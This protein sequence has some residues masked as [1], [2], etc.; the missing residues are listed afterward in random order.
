MGIYDA[1]YQVSHSLC[2]KNVNFDVSL[3]FFLIYM[4][5][6]LILVNRLH[7]TDFVK[8]TYIYVYT[9]FA[10]IYMTL[11]L[12]YSQSSPYKYFIEL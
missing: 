7:S 6:L 1:L 3:F 10:S 12:Y 9:G 2:D 5:C 4:L 11:Y 8:W